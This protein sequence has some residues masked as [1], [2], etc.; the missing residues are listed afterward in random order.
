MS[1]RFAHE[2]VEDLRLGIMTYFLKKS[3]MVYFLGLL[4]I[5]E[6][7]FRLTQ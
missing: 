1:L 4:V 6:I 7:V 2:T 3:A 5:S